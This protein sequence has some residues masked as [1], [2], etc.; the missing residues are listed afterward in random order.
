MPLEEML[1][2]IARNEIYFCIPFRQVFCK[3][4][5]LFLLNGRKCGEIFK[6]YLQ[7]GFCSHPAKIEGTLNMLLRAFQN[8]EKEFARAE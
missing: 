8:L 6:K 4:S 1:D 5:K 2:I 7:A 3:V